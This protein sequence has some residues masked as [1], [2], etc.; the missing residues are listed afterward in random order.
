MHVQDLITVERQLGYR[1]EITTS[2]IEHYQWICPRCRRALLGIA[3]AGTR[4]VT[5]VAQAGPL[6]AGSSNGTGHHAAT[7]TNG[8]GNARAH[9]P[10]TANH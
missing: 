8:T 10:L 3:Q 7:G 1:Y 5:P 6:A 9:A 4:P 2:P